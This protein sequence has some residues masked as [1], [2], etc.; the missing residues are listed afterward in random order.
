MI[1]GAIVAI[2]AVAVARPVRAQPASE[3]I[4]HRVRQGDS[5]ELLAA[6]YYGDRND[7]VFIVTENKLTKPFKIYPGERVRIPASRLIVTEANDSFDTL[8]GTYLGDARRGSFLA[9]F[10]GLSWDDNDI[11]AGG[12]ELEIP[13]H[14]IHTATA[15]ES[16]AAISTAFYGDAKQ[17]DVLRAYNF[18]DKTELDKGESIIV[19]A[20]HVHVRAAKLPPIDAE[21]KARRDRQRAAATAAA[22]A[23]PKAHTAWVRGDFA[24]VRAALSPIEPDLEYLDVPTAVD[25]G[26]LAARADIAFD[27]SEHALAL[28]KR[29]YERR[30]QLALSAY[31][32]SPKVIAA[33]NRSAARSS[34]LA[35]PRPSARGLQ[36]LD[37]GDQSG[38][39]HRRSRDRRARARAIPLRD[40]RPA[41]ARDRDL[42]DG[43]P[44]LASRGAL[45]DSSRPGR[46]CRDRRRRRCRRCSSADARRARSVARQ[47]RC[48]GARR[49]RRARWHG[50]DPGRARGD[51]RHDRGPRDLAG[52]GA[53]WRSRVRASVDRGDFGVARPR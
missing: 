3:A 26:L 27:D 41:R 12:T 15:P 37:A 7:A 45:A 25:V 6:E 52:G 2:V 42:D 16:L 21:A 39:S 38:C 28:F 50:R 34:E 1:R 13:F 22:R 17:A 30:R 32:E 53:A 11:I 43:K 20:L 44:T 29:V 49:R 40:P 4:N 35:R 33:W 5:L 18:L 46:P 19:P 36:W 51:T 23:L 48:S 14:V 24:A 31:R 8:A 9:D 10:N 47:A